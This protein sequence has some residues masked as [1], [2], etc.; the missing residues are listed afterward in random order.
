M[1]DY[2]YTAVNKSGTEVRGSVNADN[3]DRAFREIKAMGMIPIE[4]SERNLLNKSIQLT[5]GRKPKTRELAVFCRQFAS[6]VRAGV[7]VIETMRML[8]EQTENPSLKNAID[9]VRA[10]LEKGEGLATS[11]REF[12]REFPSLLVSMVAAGEASGNLDNALDRMSVQFEKSAKT[13]GMLKK[14]MIYP[15]VLLLI[16]V[17]VVAIMLI[18]VIPMFTDMFEQMGAELPALT[19]AV[20]AMSDFMI[21]NWAVLLVAVIAIVF[22]LRAW[23]STESGKYASAEIQFRIAPIRTLVVRSAAAHMARTLSTLISAGIPLIEA[24]DIVAKT[25]NNVLIRDVFINAK[26]QV[27]VGVPLSVPLQESGIFPP[28]VAHMLKVGEEVGNTEEM[29]GKLADYYDEEVEQ[30]IQGLM[31]ALEPLIIVIL[32]IIVGLLAASVVFPLAGM[33]TALESI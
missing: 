10:N 31:S 11:M 28:M 22:G 3:R 1:P 24:V 12:P 4:I 2:G 9:S 7:T 17:V 19:Q 16:A 23:M 21:A 27:M 6:M 29:L 8:T 32:A 14:A 25:M 33:Y 5:P 20:V 13:A 15:I 18:Y 30:A 26:N